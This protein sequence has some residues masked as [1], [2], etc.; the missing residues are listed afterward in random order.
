MFDIR[1]RNDF[2]RFRTIYTG[3]NIVKKKILIFSAAA[4]AVFAVWLLDLPNRKTLDRSLLEHMQS[5]SVVYDRQGNEAFPLYGSQTRHLVDIRSLPA[6]VPLAFIAAEDQRFFEHGGIDVRRIFGA[7]LSNLRQGELAEGASTITQQLIKLTHLSGEKTFRRKLQEAR[8]AVQAERIYTK[9]E[10]LQMYMNVIYFGSG[11]Y[12]IEAAAQT[13][14]GKP[15][16][17][18]SISE[19][20]LLAGIIKAPNHYSPASHPEKALQRRDYVL[21]QMEK[22]GFIDSSQQQ[23]AAA[24]P[25]SLAESQEM[26][27]TGWYRDAVIGEAA[28][29]LGLSGS[30]ILGGGYRIET[31][32][33]V[34][35]QQQMDLC[36]A[37]SE[38]FPGE[39]VQGAMIAVNPADGGILA[40]S[41]GRSDDIRMALN[42]ALHSR[43]QPGS[44][45]KPV[46]VY[47]AAVD[48]RGMLP[49]DFTDDTRR[50]FSGGYFPR[51]AGDNYYGTVTLR[52][53]LSRSLN[54]A[55][56]SLAEQIGLPAVRSYAERFGIPLDDDDSGLALAL[57]SMTY[58][59]TPAEIAGAYASLANSGISVEPHV[60]SRIS[61]SA[62]NTIYQYQ[63]SRQRILSKESAALIAD[64]LR[65]AASEGSAHALVSA[66]IPVAGK[67]GT[68]AEQ[69]GT[70]DI[71]TAAFTPD[72]SLCVWMGYDS[73]DDGAMPQ[74]A[75]G[76]GYPAKMA[77]QYLQRIKNQLSGNDF[78][79]PDTL[80]AVDLDRISLQEEHTVLLA[81][82]NTPSSEII[83]EIFP[84]AKL[85]T[86]ISDRYSL[87]DGRVNANLSVNAAGKPVIRFTAV[88]NGMEY[89]LLRHQGGHISRIAALTAAKGETVEYT[90]SEASLLS[91]AEYQ[92]IICRPAANASQSPITRQAEGLL[93][94]E[95]AAAKFRRDDPSADDG[96]A[97]T[98]AEPLFAP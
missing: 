61:D 20:A 7:L 22:C 64:M 36:M 18:I 39:G 78:S 90:D 62:G 24:E 72:I 21:A 88:Q 54:V 98:P 17:E 3:V 44:V 89:L 23:A 75:S 10:I 16:A 53:A 8:L 9:E 35:M 63:E 5:T 50:V 43:R 42:R 4:I 30:E 25:V 83:R 47:A 13:Y 73:A 95:P 85:P 93:R 6:H 76:S 51:N 19:A 84:K 79:L 81:G 14:F 32:L 37:Q 33:D 26:G 31:S 1:R 46:S 29:V 60:I 70:R 91:A 74:D 65:T 86:R 67:T 28:R 41:G 57:G 58:G 82:E 68:V 71:W 34:S 11:A 48:A 97:A 66:G 12:G 87:P 96:E 15:A 94:F 40:V 92:I 52:T 38:N 2:P 80:A 55:A 49:S 56:V 27:I 77:A 69:N 59:V 45:L